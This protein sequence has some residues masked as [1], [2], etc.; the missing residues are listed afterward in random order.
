MNKIVFL[1][2]IF[3]RINLIFYYRWQRL[4]SILISFRFKHA[5]TSIF[6]GSDCLIRG[7]EYIS[8]KGRFIALRRNRIEAIDRHGSLKFSPILIFGDNVTMEYDCHIAAINRI[9][10]GKNVL[11]A[12]KVYI[13]DHSHGG[14]TKSDISLPPN[15][16]PIIS[17]GPVLIEDNVWLGENVVVLPNVRIGH[18][19]IIGANSVVTKDIPACVLAAG[20]PAKII[21]YI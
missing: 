2:A 14:T 8:L 21:K 6:I 16:R 4:I 13:S 12:S 7:Y 20:S 17:K 15:D 10:I 3:Q 18:S 5:N 9:E 1:M 19:A 11:I